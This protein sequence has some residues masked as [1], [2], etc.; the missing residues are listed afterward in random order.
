M[1]LHLLVHAPEDIRRLGPLL[2]AST[3]HF[4]S[5]NGIF[6]AASIFSNHQAPSRDIARELADQEGLKHR[7]SG[8]WW[9][10]E[11]CDGWQ[12]AG[13]GIRQFFDQSVML[14]GLFGWKSEKRV[15]PGRVKNPD[16]VLEL[17]SFLLQVPSNWRPS[18]K[19]LVSRVSTSDRSCPTR[20]LHVLLPSIRITLHLKSGTM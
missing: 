4:E 1:K 19:S 8:G 11:E 7:L 9:R 15:N 5:F 3:E 17:I 18:R 2:G 13:V 20:I 10:S 16:R 6:R 14:Q 12:Q